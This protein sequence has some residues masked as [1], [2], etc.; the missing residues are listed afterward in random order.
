MREKKVHLIGIAGRGMSALALML[1]QK[2]FAVSGSC[3]LAHNPFINFLRKNGVKNFA[4]GYSPANIPKDADLIVISKAAD[5][6]PEDNKEVAQAFKTGIKIQSLPETLGQLAENTENIVVAGSFGKSTVTSL[7]AW[8]L[9]KNGKKP[10]YFIGAIPFGL[11]TSGKIGKGKY[12]VMEGDEYPSSNWDNRSKFLHLH[13]KNLILISAEHDH[14]N[15]FPTEEEYIKPYKDLV[16][17]LPKNGIIVA[18][19]SGKNVDKVIKH[20]KS[21]IIKYGLGEKSGWHPEN[22]IYGKITSFDLFKNK[23]KVIGLK[24][25]L[26]GKHNIENITGISAF[27]LEKKIISA[28]ELQKS[29]E[30]FKGLSGRLDLKT[31]KSSVLV[32]ES[33]GSSYA[34]ARTDFEAIKLHFPNKRVVTVFEP[35]TFS[36]R[37]RNAIFWYDDIFK[38]SDETIVFSPPEHGKST[39]DQVGLEEILKRVK[40]FKKNVYGAKNK[41]ET[42]KKLSAIVRPDDL[43]ILMSSGRIGGLMEEI[44][45]WAEKKFPR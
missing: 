41:R 2:G 29:V 4:I 17:I 32:Y 44:P 18:S 1:K 5:L 37:N 36:W 40:K 23:K 24:T 27:L 43:I 16:S 14:V 21:K 42:M 39:H 19:R 35:H 13:P 26:L 38:D 28:R 11:K 45:V 34:K 6:T 8:C 3:H 31:K 15:V 10:S 22:I 9:E 25:T 33:F 20:A 7:L 12:F 30:S